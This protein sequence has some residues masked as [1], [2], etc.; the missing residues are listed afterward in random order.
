MESSPYQRLVATYGLGARLGHPNIL[1]KYYPDIL[2][3][4]FWCPKCGWVQWVTDLQLYSDNLEWSIPEE[5]WTYKE[6]WEGKYN[7]D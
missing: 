3:T 4:K 1:R 2:E 7:E 5:C 6:R